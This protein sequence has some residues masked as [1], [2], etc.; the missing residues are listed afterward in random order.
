MKQNS[1]IIKAAS[2]LAG[3]LYRITG[4][5]EVVGVIISAALWIDKRLP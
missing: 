3:L 4:R 1:T 2:W 5:I